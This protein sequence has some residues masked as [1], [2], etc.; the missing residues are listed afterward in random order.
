MTIPPFGRPVIAAVLALIA[1]AMRAEDYSVTTY[2]GVGQQIGA[3]DGTQGSTP[4]PMFNN[5][6]GVAI[7]SAKN[8]YVADT[9]ANTIRKITPGRVVSTFAGSAGNFGTENGTGTAARLN[10]PVGIATDS[11]GNV[12]VSDSRSFTIRKITPAG[13]VSTF[14]GTPFQI[15]SANGQ[16][17]A[18]RFFLPY[19]LATDSAGNVYVA[20]GGN[21]VIRK[22]TPDGTVSTFVGSAGVS[23]TA[24]G[25][26]TV[27]RFNTPFG[28]AIDSGGNVFVTDSENNTIR[29]VTPAGVVTTIAGTAGVAGTAD[30]T[31]TAARFNRPRGIAVDGNG[32]LFVTDYSNATLRQITPGGVVLTL[33]GTAGQQG[34]VDS[35]G[36]AARFF[37]PTGIAVDGNALYIADSTNNT[38]R[39]A[40]PASAA[41]LPTITVNP[42]DQEVAVGQGITLRVFANGASSYQ[43]L[44]NGEPVVGATGS[45][46]SFAST[47][48]SDV[49]AYS[50]RISNSGG[51]IDSAT[52]NLSVTPVGTGAI[53]ISSRPVSLQV[54][55]GQPASFTVVAAGTNLTYQWLKNGST[56]GGATGTTY[57]VNSAQ[58][59]D[60][61]TYTVVITSGEASESA[62][63]K[64]FVGSNTGPG[65]TISTQ[66]VSRTV[67]AGASA[68]FSVTVSGT[69][70]VSYQWYKNDAPIPGANAATYTIAQTAL[71]DSGNFR[72]RVTSSAGTV[73]SDP[74]TLTV[75]APPIT[76]RLSNLSILTTLDTGGDFTMGYVVGGVGTS[77]T[78]PIL[79]RAAGPT[80]GAAPFNIPGVLPDP[81]IELFHG[82]NKT[83]ENDNWGGSAGLSTAF[84]AVGAFS[85]VSATSLDS[86]VLANIP[87]GD[88]S[89]KVSPV[90]NGSGTVIAEIYDSTPIAAM[91]P[92][93]PRLINVS[94]L[95]PLGDGL[96]MGFVIDGNGPKKVLIRAVGPT[97]G[98]APFNVPGAVADPQLSL[99]SGQTVINSN[100]NW[101]GTAELSAAFS[102]VGAFQLPAASKDAA[103][104][105]TLQ[106][107][108]YTVQVKGVNNTTGV[109]IVEVY[110][111]SSN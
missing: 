78:K 106:P 24:D 83:T 97:I 77:G 44:K 47:Q 109:A 18:A 43:W 110:E 52:G 39:R 54:D 46:I 21:H 55:S 85:Y 80:L 10:F 38:I 49:G 5:P 108:S 59:G 13:V 99:F 87:A 28:L 72:V 79:I 111:M 35:V 58:A 104:V 66:P 73:D 41:S 14:A 71:T 50:V 25:A 6:Y 20:D 81:K 45:S 101:G 8:I 90:G 37:D 75:N 42:L 4:N 51:G 23:G 22:I 15:G 91:T 93:T 103:L 62:S 11:S 48:Q 16:G 82:S 30:G 53:R 69:A 2:A 32:N 9:L 61:A 33:A 94:V 7:D 89:V 60:A 12:Y 95:K 27:A 86:A 88:N 29:K 84:A 57:T 68:T 36:A 105:A 19:G 67:T 92:A 26:A 56:I 64:L 74:V 70:A 107:G 1:T 3:V 76:S 17:A 100:D 34:S 98:A 96:T 102:A 65:F 40:V 31:G 63:A